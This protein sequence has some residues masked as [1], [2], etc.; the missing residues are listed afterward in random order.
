MKPRGAIVAMSWV[1]A[2][3]ALSTP[4]SAAAPKAPAPPQAAEVQEPQAPRTD[5]S[6]RPLR[7]GYPVFR[8]GQ[9]YSLKAGETAREV[10]VIFGDVVIEGRV[11]RDVVVVLG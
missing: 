7:W 4:L 5:E 3:T 9:G 2:L 1:A 10:T 11:D 6:E 8:L